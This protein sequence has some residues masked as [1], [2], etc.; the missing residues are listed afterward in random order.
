MF[1][2]LHSSPGKIKRFVQMVS[3]FT[4]VAHI[5]T[6]GVPT[7]R[8]GEESEEKGEVEVVRLRNP[9]D[10]ELN[11]EGLLEEE[12]SCGV[13]KGRNAKAAKST[14]FGGVLRYL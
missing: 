10:L 7:G 11:P 9:S 6:S 2:C 3:H 14:P 5:K 4:R 8:P 12:L 13:G 1:C